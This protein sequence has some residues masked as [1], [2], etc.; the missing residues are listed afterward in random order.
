MN[1]EIK[2][3]NKFYFL[4]YNRFSSPILERPQIKE[5]EKIAK[6]A[7]N[8]FPIDADAINYDVVCLKSSHDLSCIKCKRKARNGRKRA[9]KSVLCP[10]KR[11]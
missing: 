7:H 5:R 8:F 11:S 3:D 6:S 4:I 1:S 10:L 9:I 2:M